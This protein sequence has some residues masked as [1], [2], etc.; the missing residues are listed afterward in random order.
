MLPHDIKSAFATLKHLRAHVGKHQEARAQ[1]FFALL[2]LALGSLLTWALIP[3]VPDVTKGGVSSSLLAVAAGALAYA[4]ILI[5]FVVNLMLFSGRVENSQSYSP[6]E[7]DLIIP[8][9]R[10]LLYSQ[11]VTLFAAIGL[12]AMTLLGS[13]VVAAG[14]DRL[15]IG[16]IL[17]LCGGFAFL[18]VVRTAL[19]PLQ[20]YELHEAS[21]SSMAVLNRK[22][23]KAKHSRRTHEED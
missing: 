9:L 17:F 2:L 14:I 21:F 18:C 7:L 19:L 8:R 16:P 23:A 22:A 1:C 10:Y 11:M 12:S 15:A 5:G 6:E 20:I 4:A 13:L 3:A